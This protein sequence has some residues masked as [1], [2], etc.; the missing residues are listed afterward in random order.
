VCAQL[1][2]DARVLINRAC[3]ECHCQSHRL[4]VEYVMRYIVGL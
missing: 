1:K 3:V 2:A 4:T